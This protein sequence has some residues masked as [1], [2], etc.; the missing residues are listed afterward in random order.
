MQIVQGAEA[1]PATLQGVQ[2]GAYDQQL[3]QL[4]QE[5]LGETLGEL[6]LLNSTSHR[7][8]SIKGRSSSI[9]ARSTRERRCTLLSSCS[10]T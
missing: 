7:S 3:M 4:V 2:R 10:S 9:R 1:A 6:V 8:S 5:A